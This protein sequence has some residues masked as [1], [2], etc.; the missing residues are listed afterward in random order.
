MKDTA[1]SSP[2][3]QMYYPYS[4]MGMFT[5]ENNQIDFPFSKELKLKGAILI[6]GYK[7]LEFLV[8]RVDEVNKSNDEKLPL[9]ISIDGGGLSLK[10][11]QKR[12]LVFIRRC[13]TAN[14]KRP[15]TQGDLGSENY[16]PHYK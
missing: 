7:R 6:L 15:G 13:L 2:M 3:Q 11:I 5:T 9:F 16:F 4:I 12:F 10:Q 14:G 1:K 8:N